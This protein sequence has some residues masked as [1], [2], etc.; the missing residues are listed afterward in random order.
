M[1]AIVLAPL[2][3]FLLEALTQGYRTINAAAISPDRTLV[4]TAHGYGIGAK[5]RVRIW[6]V[7][8]GETLRTLLTGEGPVWTVAWSPD[9]RY[10]A[11]GDHRGVLTILATDDWQERS[12]FEGHAGLLDRIAWGPD[13]D[14]VA[15]GD[16]EGTIRVWS[17]RA[18]AL[19]FAANAHTDNIG[20]VAW[21]PAGDRIASASWDQTVAVVD[22][23]RGR[24]L[25]R[26]KGYASFVTAVAW[27]ADGKML[28]SASLGPP[29]LQIW[30]DDRPSTRIELVGHHAVVHAVVWSPTDPLL[31][32]AGGDRSARVWNVS[33]AV[34]RV[35]DTGGTFGTRAVSWS[36]DGKLVAAANEEALSIWEIGT[37][38]RLEH[39]EAHK[40]D[41][42]VNI[43]GWW[44][45]GRRLITL[46]RSDRRIKT[47][48]LGEE[49]PKTIIGVGVLTALMDMTG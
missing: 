8:T 10:L 22:G 6:D 36:A 13:S 23:S 48:V 26:V 27:S 19:L 47:W 2:A 17:A 46:G 37:G 35:L 31:A 12:R 1:V 39:V 7:E 29:Y 38:R 20:M 14:R 24:L 41:Y 45:D 4:A 42:E 44:P 25:Y 32:S 33:G 30:R 11:F 3:W 15:T 9:G 21:S 49:R 18:R 34:E 43:V 40:G 28:A 5:G 16:D